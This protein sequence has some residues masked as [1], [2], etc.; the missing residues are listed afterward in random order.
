MAIQIS[1]TNVIDNNFHIV[2]AQ[3]GNFA[4]II[5][6]TKFVGSNGT[7]VAKRSVGIAYI[8]GQ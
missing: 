1:G 3:N 5:T 8:L 2:S 4:G 6:A 7:D